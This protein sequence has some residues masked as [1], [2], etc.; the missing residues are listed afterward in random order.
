MRKIQK[1]LIGMFFGGVLLGGIGTG[2]A[3][4]EYSS[5]AYA[6]E[7]K[8]GEENLVTKD[9]DYSFDP[10]RGKI[11]VGCG[12][13][14]YEQYGSHIETDETVPQGMIRYAITYN[15]RT[16]QPYLIYDERLETEDDSFDPEGAADAAELANIDEGTDA[17]GT[18]YEGS[19]YDREAE[20]TVAD[21]EKAKK[22]ERI[23]GHLDVGIR[24]IVSDF[25]LWM[26][27]KDA[28]LKDLKQRRISSYDVA[29]ITD[30]KIKVNPETMPYLLDE[31]R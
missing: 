5:F 18:E 10:A 26:E 11:S 1:L 25:A 19:L 21:E 14:E 12:W 3:L 2:I 13:W 24:N 27:C 16:T 20:I 17:G 30:I 9:F 4:V 29:Y 28:V 7:K 15:D 8:I 23:Q 31:T 6:G 22:E